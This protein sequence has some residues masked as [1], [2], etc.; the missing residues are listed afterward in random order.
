MTKMLDMYH[1]PEAHLDMPWQVLERAPARRRWALFRLL[2]G[3]Q[4]S[5]E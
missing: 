1:P 2:A 3:R 4:A 5:H